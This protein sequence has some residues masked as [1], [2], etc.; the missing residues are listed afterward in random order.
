MLSF[1]RPH[2]HPAYLEFMRPDENHS[3]GLVYKHSESS[4]ILYSFYYRCLNQSQAF[5]NIGP[6]IHI[7]SPYG[8]GGPIFEG[9]EEERSDAEQEFIRLFKSE[10]TKR[11]S[12]S[13]FVREDLFRRQIVNRNDGVLIEQQKNI[14]VHLNRAHDDIWTGYKHK[15]RKNVNRAKASN[16]KVVFDIEGEYLNEFVKIYHDTMRRTEA[17]SKFFIPKDK[18]HSLVDSLGQDGGLMFAHVFSGGRMVSTELLL[19]S[20]TVLF[21][22][23]GGTLEDAFDAR[24]N[25]LLKHETILWGSDN[26]YKH[27]VLGGG[28]QPNDGIFKYK[29]AFDPDGITP[30]YIRKVIHNEK[31]YDQLVEARDL[32]EKKQNRIWSPNEEFFPKYLS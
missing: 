26:G 12:V 1:K 9:N 20:Q 7:T 29:E 28:V 2:D 3:V 4:V 10:L 30:F 16:L 31:I 6:C 17:P 8:Y 18:F 13:E 5:K 14:V 11:N 23:L 19:R 22:C 21:S 15:V 32:F 24:P 27:Y 25:D